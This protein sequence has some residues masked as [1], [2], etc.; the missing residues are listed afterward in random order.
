MMKEAIRGT[1]R[2]RSIFIV[3]PLQDPKGRSLA[4][5]AGD[6]GAGC[7]PTPGACFPIPSRNSDCGSFPGEPHHG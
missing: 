2:S 5:V 6:R 7:P 4:D 3:R 1:A